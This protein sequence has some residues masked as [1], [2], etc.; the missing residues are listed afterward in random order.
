V[1]VQGE[2]VDHER[3]AEQVEG[4]ALVADAVGAAEPEGIVEVAVD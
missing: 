4:L 3:V 2:C 1:A